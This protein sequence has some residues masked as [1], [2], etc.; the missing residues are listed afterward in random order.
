MTG[1]GLGGTP[2]AATVARAYEWL[3]EEQHSAA[4]RSGAL[5]AGGAGAVAF[6]VSASTY[7]RQRASYRSCLDA[8]DRFQAERGHNP[9]YG[10]SGLSVNTAVRICRNEVMCIHGAEIRAC[11]HRALQSRAVIAQPIE[12]DADT[13]TL[14]PHLAA[15]ALAILS[16]PVFLLLGLLLY[17]LTVAALRARYVRY[18]EGL[19]QST[20]RRSRKVKD[21]L[22]AGPLWGTLYHLAT[23]RQRTRRSLR[24]LT[25]VGASLFAVVAAGSVAVPL[26]AML[27]ILGEVQSLE[28]SYYK[29]L[30]VAAVAGD[31]ALAAVA[32]GVSVSVLRGSKATWNQV[33]SRLRD[34]DFPAPEQARPAGS[35][36]FVSFLLLPRPMDLVHKL[37]FVS[38]VSYLVGLLARPGGT[39]PAPLAML[40]GA[41]VVL[42]ELVLQQ[43]RYAL[44][45]TLD[46]EADRAD[47]ARR[48]TRFPV[49]AGLERMAV[50]RKV[51]LLAVAARFVAW[52]AA[53]A[54]IAARADR[55]PRYAVAMAASAGALVTLTILYE[56]VSRALRRAQSAERVKRRQLYGHLTL[57]I[58]GAGFGLRAGVGV[59]FATVDLNAGRQWP[60]WLAASSFMML[61]GYFVFSM[62]KAVDATRFLFGTLDY[63]DPNDED[64]YWSESIEKR[65]LTHFIARSIGWVADRGKCVKGPDTIAVVSVDRRGNKELKREHVLSGGK[66]LRPWTPEVTVQVGTAP[67]SVRDW[68]LRCKLA[69]YRGG[70]PRRA[71]SW[72]GWARGWDFAV[73][74]ASTACVSL[75]V[76]IDVSRGDRT[77]EASK[78]SHLGLVIA[79]PLAAGLGMAVMRVFRR[80]WR[81]QEAGPPRVGPATVIEA[82]LFAGAGAALW[83]SWQAPVRGPLMKAYGVAALLAWTATTIPTPTIGRS[84]RA[85]LAA[86][87]ALAAPSGTGESDQGWGRRLRALLKARLMSW[88]GYLALALWVGSVSYSAHGGLVREGW[89]GL[90]SAWAARAAYFVPPLLLFLTLQAFRNSSDFEFRSLMPR[91]FSSRRRKL[92]S[93]LDDAAGEL[94]S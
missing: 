21:R 57:L 5:I 92:L 77:I 35:R 3:L 91:V 44:N 72:A 53:A 76:V 13:A 42:F 6:T 32:I 73:V 82:A 94:G 24:V 36:S 87:G 41:C 18:L 75:S 79:A 11:D 40:G 38:V 64:P 69:S 58:G 27:S 9:I 62:G 50:R 60:V 17:N 28:A 56:S 23:S 89:A 65:P 12:F 70:W 19:L 67:V 61:L 83:A 78:L 80:S 34:Y 16:L 14:D 47:P 25:D 4:G 71:V 54:L 15:G 85:L 2:E 88:P 31:A 1:T 39:P 37:L 33:T 22:A 81:N 86:T 29:W 74:L 59:V 84:T 30:P 55:G 93:F 48:R 49:V 90:G 45:D 51:S 68:S 7:L 66:R 26:V 8:I 46:I 63:E 10:R 43:G 52:V 20:P